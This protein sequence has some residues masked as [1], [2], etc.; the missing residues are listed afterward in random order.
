MKE[1]DPMHFLAGLLAGFFFGMCVLWI[2]AR[3]IG[4]ARADERAAVLSL[5]KHTNN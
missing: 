5:G 1:E 2:Y 3:G 4:A